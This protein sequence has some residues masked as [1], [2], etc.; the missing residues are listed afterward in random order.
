MSVKRILNHWFFVMSF[1]GLCGTALSAEFFF[2]KEAILESFDFS[3][4]HLNIYIS[5]VDQLYIA[6]IA[7]RFAW[8]YH[9]YIGVLFSI[10][11]LF[12]IFSIPT[13]TKSITLVL[14]KII[15]I[16]SGIILSITGCLLYLRIYIQISSEVFELLKI[17]HNNSKWLFIA[18]VILHIY[19]VVI[20]E[21]RNY[22]GIISSMFSKGK[23]K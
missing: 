8:D 2:S 15:I 23:V 13:N 1:L 10:S 11:I 20:L 19:S 3:L 7:R 6:R 12:L 5:P 9:F 18:A 17:I 21:N 14:S 16:G 22:K 4:N